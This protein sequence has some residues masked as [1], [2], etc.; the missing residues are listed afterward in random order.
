MTRRCAFSG[1]FAP[2]LSC[3]DGE[4]KIEDCSHWKSDA[5]TVAAG[6]PQ[7]TA[8]A[9]SGEFRFPWTGNAMGAADLNY[10]A[11]AA[12]TRLVT[13]AGAADAGKTSL[14]AAFYLLIAR[15]VAPE[16]VAFSGSL[17][18][19]GWEN[20]AS[21]L[22]WSSQCGPS[23]PPHT[24]S[25]AGRRPGLLHLSLR[26]PEN[27]RELLAADAPG[28]WFS[29]WATNKDAQQ[30]EGARWLAECS[31]VILVI[32]DSQALAG[33]RRGQARKGLV[34]LLRRVGGELNRRPVALV[35]TKSDIPVPA[36]MVTAIEEAATRSLNNYAKFRV[37]MHPAANGEVENQGQG[38]LGLL[39]WVLTATPGGYEF[40]PDDAP[41]CALFCAF[42][43]F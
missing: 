10:L 34:D 32:A 18:L 17:T 6:E 22:R 28:E 3:A 39:Y 40:Q 41:E 33:P 20:I 26:T 27:L 42:G 36:D 37:S 24:S 8:I 16:G 29:E 19:E 4:A 5:E 12:S 25:G 35:W 14:L 1:C 2:E 11:G 30:A 43:R 38:I 21:S 13:L 7:N 31:D 15:G 9:V 23:F